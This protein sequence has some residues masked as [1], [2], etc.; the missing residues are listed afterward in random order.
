MVKSL[1]QFLGFNILEVES[2]I[3]NYAQGQK[4]SLLIMQ[5]D[6]YNLDTDSTRLC[7]ITDKKG[8]II[9]MEIG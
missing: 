7:V 3:K 6:D 5:E 9:K 1:N 2:K 8:T 4:L